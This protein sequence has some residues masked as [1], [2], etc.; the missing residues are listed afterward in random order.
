M[1]LL[2]LAFQLAFNTNL[3]SSYVYLLFYHL[4]W[5]V[6][7]DLK[8]AFSFNVGKLSEMQGLLD[9]FGVIYRFPEELELILK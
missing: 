6:L 2:L 9:L 7:P 3:Q 1:I 5:F 4:F 8:T